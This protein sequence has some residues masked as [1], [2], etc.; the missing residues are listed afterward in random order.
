MAI[1]RSY[2]A[3]VIGA[4]VMGSVCA[5]RLADAGLSVAIVEAEAVGRG[6]SG[7]NAGTLTL[8]MVHPRLIPHAR[9]GQRLWEN[10]GSW[11]GAPIPVVRKPGLSLAFTDDEAQLLEAKAQKRRAF[12]APIELITADRAREVDPAIS[13][14]VRLAALSPE[15]GTIVSYQ[16]AHLV[17]RRL[18]RSGV[19][20]HDRSAVRRVDA[21]GG[22]YRLGI[23]HGRSLHGR[24]IVLAGGHRLAEMFAWFGLRLPITVRTFQLSLLERVPRFLDAVVTVADERLSL[25]QLPNGTTIVGGGWEGTPGRGGA[26]AE[27]IPENLVGNMRLAAYC[28][29]AVGDTR[30]IRVWFGR[31][32]ETGDD[33]P[34]LGPLP[35]WPGVWAIGAAGS[36][37][38]CG[39]FLGRALADMML[40]RLPDEEIFPPDRFIESDSETAESS[41]GANSVS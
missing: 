32:A 26:P 8:H 25:K 12:G 28:V 34:V 1:E 30:L 15:D 3:V 39:P 14:A 10:S 23:Q 27:I 17:K 38:T 4:G 33:L 2:D 20:I 35:G 7:R 13:P 24:Q 9:A 6:A 40:G 19:D 29:P 36:G 22:G 41:T 31:E 11:L 37:F 5:L 18:M 21:A 16:F